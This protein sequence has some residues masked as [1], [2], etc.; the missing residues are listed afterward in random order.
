MIDAKT[1]AELF[2]SKVV[3]YDDDAHAVS[4]GASVRTS[5]DDARR[6]SGPA[7]ADEPTMRRR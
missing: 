6:P 3:F 7:L 5:F 1:W 2:A 4:S